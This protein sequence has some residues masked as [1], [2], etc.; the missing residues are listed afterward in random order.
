MAAETIDCNFRGKEYPPKANMPVAN[1]DVID[2]EYY[3]PQER[4]E[5]SELEPEERLKKIDLE[6][7]STFTRDQ[8]IDESKRCFSC[9]S[10]FDCGTC[11]SICQDQAIHKPVRKFEEYTFKMDV[12]KGCFKCV[13]ACPCGYIEMRNPMNNEIAKRDENR[14][15]L[16]P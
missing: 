7:S 3:Q 15:V 12:C 6:I 1:K 10:C 14:K 5:N 8:L 13:E 2:L 4:N 9:G 16:Y 11:W